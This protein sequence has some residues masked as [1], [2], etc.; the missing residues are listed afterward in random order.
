[1]SKAVDIAI[2]VD[3][4]GRDGVPFQAELSR[5]RWLV[6]ASAH[7][8]VADYTS[9]ERCSSIKRGG[10]KTDRGS[11]SDDNPLAAGTCEIALAIL[12]RGADFLPRFGVRIVPYGAS[13]SL[14]SALRRAFHGS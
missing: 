13:N 10:D 7:V 2:L 5:K 1:M 3:H 14:S 6:A 12:R 8:P 9:P 11:V 4:G